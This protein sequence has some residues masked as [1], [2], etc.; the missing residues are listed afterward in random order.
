[1]SLWVIPLLD[2]D[3]KG[4]EI[5]HMKPN[6]PV[7]SPMT[8]IQTRIWRM[9]NVVN[10]NQ[11]RCFGLIKTAEY[12]NITL[13]EKAS[14]RLLTKHDILKSNFTTVQ[15]MLYPLQTVLDT[16]GLT[17]YKIECRDIEELNESVMVAKVREALCSHKFK[18]DVGPLVC[19]S[20]M[21]HESE[22]TVYGVA[23]SSLIGDGYSV[24]VLLSEIYMSLA[25]GS[26]VVDLDSHNKDVQFKKVWQW[27]Q[28]LL[29]LPE[30]D[31][32][33]SYWRINFDYIAQQPSL[34]IEIPVGGTDFFRLESCECTTRVAFMH[35][36]LSIK[37][38]TLS[39]RTDCYYLSLWFILLWRLLEEDGKTSVAIAMYGRSLPDLRNVIGPL[40][41][42]LP[43]GIDIRKSDKLEDVM[44]QC[45][46]ALQQ[47]DECQDC[48]S[49][50]D[51][52]TNNHAEMGSFDYCFEY[53][54]RSLLQNAGDTNVK[55]HDHLSCYDKFK[56]KLTVSCV[57]SESISLGIQYDT[58]FFLKNN[59]ETLLKCYCYWVEEACQDLKIRVSEFSWLSS[60]SMGETVSVQNAAF[61]P[62]TDKLSAVAQ[63]YPNRI[64]FECDVKRVSY[65]ELERMT[66]IIAAHILHEG[67]SIESVIAVFADRSIFALAGL[68][69]ILKAGCVM[70]YIDPYEPQ[71]RIAKIFSDAK[72]KTVL[73]ETR[74]E[75]GLDELTDF[76]G[77]CAE[78][79]V[80][81]IYLDEILNDTS[82]PI[83][84]PDKARVI[85]SDQLAYII[86]TSGSNGHPKGVMISHGSLSGQLNWILTQYELLEDDIFLAKTPLGFD[87]SIWEWLTPLIIGAKL[88]LAKQTAHYEADYMVTLIR[89][90]SVTILQVVPSQ[91][92][93]L[94]HSKDFATLESLRLVFCGGERLGKDLCN[95]FSTQINAQLVNLYGPTETTINASHWKIPKAKNEIDQIL[96]GKPV[97]GMKAIVLDS[98]GF[99]LPNGFYG[100]LG[101]MG[102]GLARGYLGRPALTAD[103][104]RPST[105]NAG[106]RVYLTGD[107]V[108]YSDQDLLYK[109]RKDN[110]VK[111]SGYRI[112]LGEIEQALLSH[113]NV[114]GAVVL[115]SHEHDSLQG[116]LVAYVQPSSEAV[117]LDTS[118]LNKYIKSYLPDY[119]LPTLIIIMD[120]FPLNNN[121]KIDK[122]L[123]ASRDFL[124]TYRDVPYV[125]PR[126]DA[127]KKLCGLWQ[128]ILGHERIGID[129]HFFNLGGHSLLIS[130][131][132]A[133]VSENIGV[134]LSPRVVFDA[135]VLKDIAQKIE[136][137]QHTIDEQDINRVDKQIEVI[138]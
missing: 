32:A 81:I 29:A 113:V 128:E 63:Q 47:A 108:G 133:A 54:D 2:H 80:D 57:N 56:L 73:I 11:F 120:R 1:M 114:A 124:N 17:I 126:T 131:F 74:G 35:Q 52:Q 115:V 99:A 51:F 39:Q 60:M 121:R 30:S 107:I 76:I 16:P 41:N 92:Q 118:I 15:G 58:N 135:P 125:A 5:N 122:K 134:D 65:I 77:R 20:Y 26:S 25:Q 50:S 19:F 103:R 49:W 43:V 109:Y 96:I 68:L 127:E 61:I 34:S 95:S 93:A 100:E 112:E 31:F 12:F 106:Q 40:S 69:S 137:L 45:M 46:L 44:E 21:A 129:D 87:A 62:I 13:F 27:R 4:M 67:N 101:L 132:V 119:M 6:D 55:I 14:E 89:E 123:M 22:G 111:L 110:Q 84:M 7:S 78:P 82:A 66:N 104:F 72:V 48:F 18:V 9:M 90:Y 117:N 88:V 8:D 64:A 24:D 38:H 105:Y 23:L 59:V 116:M 10:K 85:S 138:I 53:C 75:D 71:K 86:Y 97:E 28:G 136:Q 37:D 91:L 42:H 3:V 70:L 102:L 94:V 33:R 83:L 36:L 98:L 130:R 79:S